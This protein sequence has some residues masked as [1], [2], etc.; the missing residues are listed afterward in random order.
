MK[1][2]KLLSGIPNANTVSVSVVQHS[3]GSSSTTSSWTLPKTLDEWFAYADDRY[4]K[5][6]KITLEDIAETTHHNPGYVRQIHAEYRT[7]HP[8]PPKPPKD[9][10]NKSRSKK[11]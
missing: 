10:R 5:G 7:E 8:K 1:R 3:S 6:Y 11:T 4:T 2:E 9:Q